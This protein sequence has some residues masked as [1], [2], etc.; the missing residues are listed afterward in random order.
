M[1]IFELLIS[2]FNFFVPA[3]TAYNPYRPHQIENS[4][5]AEAKFDGNITYLGDS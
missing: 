4:S 5:P 1:N 2:T 3:F